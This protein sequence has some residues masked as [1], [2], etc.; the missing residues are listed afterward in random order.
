VAQAAPAPEA[1]GWTLGAGL[2]AL[3]SLG[4]TPDPLFG[5]AVYVVAG[6]ESPGVWAPELVLGLSHQWL[7]G[8]E[9]AGGDADFALNA[10]NIELCPARFGIGVL[11]ARPCAAAWLGRFSAQGYETYDARSATRPW[12]TLG[13]SLQLNA[14]FGP[15]ELRG[16]FG[17]G[18]PL[19][20]DEFRF[21]GPCSGSACSEDA[22]HQVSPVIWSFVFGAGAG[23]W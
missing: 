6:W 4:I 18:V 7:D 17:A 14:R 22:F 1:S 9:Q 20:R 13:A 5:G 21:G 16:A 3:A 2:S 8:S 11:E 19:A 23:L 15:V 10:A 12:T